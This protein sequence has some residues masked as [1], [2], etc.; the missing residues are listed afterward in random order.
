MRT[1]KGIS[2]ARA[3]APVAPVGLDR[4]S[5][6]GLSGAKRSR[7][8]MC[9]MPLDA[10]G[11]WECV[12]ERGVDVG[13]RVGVFPCLSCWSMFTWVG[14]RIRRN[15]GGCFVGGV[16]CHQIRINRRFSVD[17]RGHWLPQCE[18]IHRTRSLS[19]TGRVLN[20]RVSTSGSR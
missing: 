15:W 12:L 7:H 2:D 3:H 6:G 4:P 17:A 16:T 11:G 14:D 13:V 18:S 10:G 9:A 19:F 20:A 1:P 5:E 8:R